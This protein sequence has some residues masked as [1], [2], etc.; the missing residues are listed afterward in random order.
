M[1]LKLTLF[2]AV[3]IHQLR[4]RQRSPSSSST[5]RPTSICRTTMVS[6]GAPSPVDRWFVEGSDLPHPVWG[7]P[8]LQPP[9][10][11]TRDRSDPP[12]GGS[13]DRFDVRLLQRAGPQRGGLRRSRWARQG[14]GGWTFSEAEPSLRVVVSSRGLTKN[15][16]LSPGAHRLHGGVYGSTKTQYSKLLAS[17]SLLLTMHWSAS[18]LSVFVPGVCPPPRT[19][20][21]TTNA[22]VS[23][24]PQMRRLTLGGWMDH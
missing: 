14:E 5:A 20:Q 19:V 7:F 24:N 15:P 3:R 16:L 17:N 21:D 11:A 18:L 13:K 12:L 8:R 6:P 23:W 22:R 2:L 1:W 9:L 4:A 10:G